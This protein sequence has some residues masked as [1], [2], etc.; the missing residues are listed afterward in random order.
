MDRQYRLSAGDD[1]KIVAG[2]MEDAI[3]ASGRE[4]TIDSDDE[5]GLVIGI[6]GYEGFAE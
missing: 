2:E 3:V 5:R 1:I 6:R 4:V